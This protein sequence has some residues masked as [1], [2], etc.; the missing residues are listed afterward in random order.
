MPKP[1]SVG[2]P[3]GLWVVGRGLR[4][5]ATGSRGGVA[6][7]HLEE[8]T[9]PGIKSSSRGR[10]RAAQVLCM[11]PP[12][13]DLKSGSRHKEPIVL[14][15]VVGGTW[16]V[17]RSPPRMGPVCLPCGLRG[18]L[19][20]ELWPFLGFWLTLGP[21][22]FS[23]TLIGKAVPVLGYM[24]PNCRGQ[25][26]GTPCGMSQGPVTQWALGVLPELEMRRLAA[27]AGPNVL[28]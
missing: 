15:S 28:Q 25:P 26:G 6:F 17:Q 23:R 7:C 1:S 5:P 14:G 2:G 11:G 16:V 24:G 9:G 4:S 22:V 18:H 13:G 12:W 8:G 10:P 19:P 3:L 27:W 21:L 20:H